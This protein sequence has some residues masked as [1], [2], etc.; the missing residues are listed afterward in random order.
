MT[1]IELGE[2]SPGSEEP[3]PRPEFGPRAVRRLVV[4]GVVLLCA[5]TLG[6]SAR[7]GTPFVHEIWSIPATGGDQMTLRDDGMFLHRNEDGRARI[8]AYETATGTVRWT[9]QSEGDVA[10][11]YQGEAAGLLLF[12]G[13]EKFADITFDDGGQGQIAYGGT[14]TALEA[15][16]GRWRWRVPGEVQFV[17][18]G[19]VLL[20]ERDVTGDLTTIRLVGADDGADLW[21]REWPG[22]RHLSVQ[23][24]GDGP[25]RIVVAE[26]DGA[27]TALR[28][29][30]GAVLAERRLSWSPAGPAQV[31]DTYLYI[32]GPVLLVHRNTQ[33]E[34]SVDAYHAETL[35]PLW[36]RDTE[37]HPGTQL[38]GPV[39]CLGEATR[40]TGLEPL[41][42]RTRWELPGGRHPQPIDDHRMLVA[43]DSEYPPDQFLADPATGTR[44]GAAVRGWS[45]RTDPDDDTV[46]I[47]GRVLAPG[48]LRTSVR[49]LDLATGRITLVGEVVTTDQV[50][51]EQCDSVPGYLACRQG[52]RLVVT[53]V[54]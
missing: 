33:A 28:Y 1:V 27:A 16:T 40:M 13:G 11:M 23:D 36:S 46:V 21:R 3:H 47:L 51:G 8:T 48:P 4:A 38:C 49:H 42:G 52:D 15:A 14:T 43:A 41:T 19:A 45:L 35:E 22:L 2:V 17:T 6:A 30:D 54:S 5:L 7:P 37:S 31:M 44:I 39:I 9:R 25:P 10:W 29:S 18:A 12:S 26:R 20:A 53:A 24:E 50:G 34:G 32:A